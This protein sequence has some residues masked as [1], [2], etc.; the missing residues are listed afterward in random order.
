MSLRHK[1]S[2]L[3]GQDTERPVTSHRETRS[4]ATVERP[5]T[6]AAGETQPL[7][8]PSRRL[9]KAASTTFQALSDSLRSKA[10]TFY[11]APS[12]SEAGLSTDSRPRTPLKAS[13]VSTI[14]S[15]VRSR[16]SRRNRSAF[17]DTLASLD[18][19]PTTPTRSERSSLESE[20]DQSP[21]EYTPI[22]DA[23]PRISTEI[24]QSSFEDSLT[25]DDGDVTTP[26][27]T[28]TKSGQ[29]VKNSQP[30]TMASTFRCEP[31][32]I[33]PSP[34]MRL[35]GMTLVEQAFTKVDLAETSPQGLPLPSLSNT[36]ISA[37]DHA[38]SEQPIQNK[39]IE[40]DRS[41]ASENS[42]ASQSVAKGPCKS[43]YDRKPS[44]DYKGTFWPAGKVL[45]SSKRF[46][47][48]DGNETSAEA[49]MGPR[50]PW[51]TAQAN[52]RKRHEELQSTYPDPE[53]LPAHKPTLPNKNPS[54]ELDRFVQ[55][56]LSPFSPSQPTESEQHS[57][58]YLLSSPNSLNTTMTKKLV[59]ISSLQV[60]KCD[61]ERP[62]SSDTAK[63]SSSESYQ[64]FQAAKE[65]N[66]DDPEVYV[67]QTSPNHLLRDLAQ[68]A[69]ERIPIP[70]NQPFD[71]T[72]LDAEEF[73]GH[74]NM[75]PLEERMRQVGD[76][77][78]G[79]SSSESSYSQDSAKSDLDDSSSD[80]VCT[81]ESGTKRAKVKPWTSSYGRYARYTSTPSPSSPSTSP[82]RELGKTYVKTYYSTGRSG[83][84]SDPVWRE[85]HQK[86]VD[87]YIA[88]QSAKY[89]DP[90]LA[91]F[92]RIDRSEEI[93]RGVPY[94]ALSPEGER[95][96]DRDVEY[97]NKV[98]AGRDINSE[99]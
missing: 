62:S 94:Y 52:R 57:Q 45:K 68:S 48:G 36:Q 6:S 23:P 51:E 3:W 53:A 98:W 20:Q 31:R 78:D 30:S 32:Y 12:Q 95:D 84:P 42:D 77:L 35:R 15:S 71:F 81:N 79:A 39:L 28:P 24:P 5:A 25:D 14:W 63:D 86:R 22:D 70:S 4:E 80:D 60:N 54:R 43:K 50:E 87:N 92:N 21:I 67:D 1:F 38:R 47:S 65:A 61:S 26:V 11:T 10:Q 58:A 56:D 19:L 33:W 99:A 18:D 69:T 74:A 55:S 85:A 83:S 76:L 75:V 8:T 97:G 46:P 29:S 91:D 72:T 89:V 34:H 82:P 66:D 44:E 37:I 49:G 41:P 13:Q 27:V 40:Y 17:K 73:Y 90:E 93:R 59:S 64:Y 7:P 2:R 96:F 9:H 88:A 16:A